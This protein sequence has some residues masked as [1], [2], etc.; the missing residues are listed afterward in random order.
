MDRSRNKRTY[1]LSYKPSCEDEEWV[2]ENFVS[3]S[4]AKAVKHQATVLLNKYGKS[5]C[6]V[7]VRSAKSK[8]TLFEKTEGSRWVC[9][10]EIS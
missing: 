10:E 6:H 1:V 3:T 8:N 7:L 9:L 2:E 4:T 5:V